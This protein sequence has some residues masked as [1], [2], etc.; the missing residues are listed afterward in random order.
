MGTIDSWSS[1]E[2]IIRQR[3]ELNE[4]DRRYCAVCGRQGP[5][6]SRCFGCQMVYYCGE[7]HQI[8]DWSKEHAQNC[9]QLEWVALG[10]FIQALPAQPPLPNVGD[11]W[12]LSLKE[13]NNWKSWFSI[14][15]NIV[16]LANNTANVLK[17]LIHLTDKRQPTHQNAIDGLLAAVTDLLTHVLTI[18][19]AVVYFGL[20]PNIRP[21]VIHILS[22]FNKIDLVG[23][24]Q[25]SPNLPARFH[26]LL[27]MFPDNKGVELVI[28][29]GDDNQDDTDDSSIPHAKLKPDRLIITTT[30]KGRLL[31]TFEE[32]RLQ[33]SI[34][35]LLVYFNAAHLFLPSNIEQLKS[36]LSRQRPTLLTFEDQE[37]FHQAQRYLST[38]SVNVQ[39][40]GSN[41]FSSLIIRQ[42]PN[43]PNATYSTNSYQ[44]LLNTMTI[45][46]TAER[47]DES[48]SLLSHQRSHQS[49]IGI[50]HGHSQQQQQ[51]LNPGLKQ[52][53]VS[54]ANTITTVQPLV[55]SN[56][57]IRQPTL[58]QRR[59]HSPPTS[60]LTSPAINTTTSY[61]AT[62]PTTAEMMTTTEIIR[63]DHKPQPKPRLSLVKT[64]DND[65]DV[66]K[67][68]INGNLVQRIK[69][70][71]EQSS[72]ISSQEP[73]V[74][75]QERQSVSIPYTYQKENNTKATCLDDIISSKTVYATSSPLPSQRV[76]TYTNG[77]IVTSS[78]IISS[79]SSI[80]IPYDERMTKT[81]TVNTL[82]IS[83]PTIERR[84]DERTIKITTNSGSS[85]S[86]MPMEI[87][88]DQRTV[89]SATTIASPP[90]SSSPL[91]SSIENRSNERIVTATIVNISPT[92]S[93]PIETHIDKSTAVM[94]IMKSNSPPPPPRPPLPVSTSS[95]T[96][97]EIIYTEVIKNR[98]RPL[99][100]HHNDLVKSTV[101]PS[102]SFIIPTKSPSI[103]LKNPS[104]N[105]QRPSRS[106]TTNNFISH[107]NKSR[108]PIQSMMTPDRISLY[109]QRSNKQSDMGVTIKN[110]SECID[111][112]GVVF[113]ETNRR[114]D[115][116]STGLTTV[117][118][119]REQLSNSSTSK[120]SGSL[121]DKLYKSNSSTRLSTSSSSRAS[122]SI[123]SPRSKSQQATKTHHEQPPASKLTPTT[124]PTTTSPPSS[125][126]Q[127]IRRTVGVFLPLTPK[128]HHESEQTNLTTSEQSPALLYQ[129]LEP[130]N[131][132]S[133]PTQILDYTLKQ[134]SGPVCI[135]IPKPFRKPTAIIEP[136]PVV[137]S[138][139]RNISEPNYIN[140]THQD[141]HI[142]TN[143]NSTGLTG[144]SNSNSYTSKTSSIYSTSDKQN[145]IT[146]SETHYAMSH[147]PS[148]QQEQSVEYDSFD[149]E[150]AIDDIAKIEKSPH[151]H[152]N[153]DND[154][155]DD[156]DDDNDD[157]NN[158]NNN[159]LSNNQSISSKNS[160]KNFFRS[161]LNRLTRSNKSLE[162][163]NN[164]TVTN[165]C[166]QELNPSNIIDTKTKKTLR[167]IKARREAK[168][169]GN[170]LIT[171][172][173]DDDTTSIDSNCS[174]QTST[175]LN[176][177]I[178]TKSSNNRFRLFRRKIEKEFASDTEAEKHQTE[179][180]R[181]K[182]NKKI[183]NDT[184]N[185]LKTK[186][187]LMMSDDDDDTHNNNN[188]NDD[189][190]ENNQNLNQQIKQNFIND[191]TH[192]Y[193][194]IIN[195]EINNNNN[196]NTLSRMGK[197]SHET[198]LKSPTI[199][200]DEIRSEIQ[201]EIAAR[202]D[203]QINNQSIQSS[204]FNLQKKRSKS[205]TFLDE[206]L[207]DDPNQ[208]Q[209]QQQQLHM[210][211]KNDLQIKPS[212]TIK[213]IEKGD[214]RSICGALTGTGPIRGII[215]AANNDITGTTAPV[216]PSAAAAIYLS[217]TTIDTRCTSPKINERTHRP[218]ST[219]TVGSAR[220]YDGAPVV[221]STPAP[222]PP[223]P[224][225][226]FNQNNN[227]NNNNNIPNHRPILN[228]S[229]HHSTSSNAHYKRPTAKVS[230]FQA[231]SPN[232][233]SSSSPISVSKQTALS[234]TSKKSMRPSTHRN[235]QTSHDITNVA[236]SS[237]S[238]GVGGVSKR[239]QSNF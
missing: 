116:P 212:T 132:N 219:Y 26:E 34:A 58:V 127:S 111:R 13:I 10:E 84:T 143:E 4:I 41:Q 217:G 206:L 45:S 189:D 188:N 78:A 126:A 18:G 171:Y 131:S 15:T 187:L 99:S 125:T 53:N 114:N 195:D 147:I 215:K 146:S 57:N 183:L 178:T 102:R 149:D 108:A 93:Q 20:Q 64:T 7:E 52:V 124:I 222:A 139:I 117:D 17:N 63:N 118:L 227:N 96:N 177:T 224:S 101:S 181:K 144:S 190:D 236:I 230:P 36:M 62:N 31:D 179:Q 24:N 164:E 81:N 237:V 85:S 56:N 200:L 196:N 135:G 38:K 97:N 73:K 61:R 65:T 201:A 94:S 214:A 142:Y 137:T 110:L 104:F 199:T 186:R 207:A 220:F 150:L 152:D 170:L 48:S 14:R 8:E 166:I 234:S 238:D 42:R 54:T 172:T 95:S 115:V 28:V 100:S 208:Q 204:N 27:N 133:S 51:Q 167:S 76:E 121:L 106:Q 156:D 213:R 75:K 109:S 86:T 202:Q 148:T 43:K 159:Q 175:S 98:E 40:A 79:P 74:I 39:H 69:P 120:S 232:E 185:E 23:N 221:P 30:G 35:D 83:K 37:E 6:L 60:I 1:I 9:T 5:S 233:S 169:T 70:F 151:S 226:S 225:H 77:R 87:H 21:L 180:R 161:T 210:I 22:G 168:K 154:S 66:T 155:F 158:N 59:H 55:R 140:L 29:I 130:H 89:M 173:G 134:H 216:S 119:I 198:H 80:E 203:I 25:S 197:L 33:Q 223:L 138:P 71:F 231:K 49:S 91:S 141:E 193:D 19:K 136:S 160:S 16:N 50:Q 107:N 72:T 123:A 153:T 218:L 46:S 184:A 192:I 128:N 182:W 191:E 122:M 209:H 32:K 165:D 205:V 162:R 2:A 12:P 176:K 3:L 68:Q 11:K 239:L 92:L 44:I 82:N 105:I 67:S 112:V 103:S 129:N 194:H 90:P 113:D 174:T 163:L 157:N 47:N 229:S 145:L 211:T 235:M 228:N 88:H